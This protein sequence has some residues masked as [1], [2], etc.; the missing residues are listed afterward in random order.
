ME[1]KKQ[2][3][4]TRT[5]DLFNLRGIR[6]VTMGEVCAFQRISKKTLYKFFRDKDDLIRSCMAFEL[7]RN[8]VEVQRIVDKGLNA[9]EESFQISKFIIDQT[10]DFNLTV[11]HEL[12]TYYPDI[13]KLFEDHQNETVRVSIIDNIERG[14]K[15][16]FYRPDLNT[17]IVVGLH[18]TLM[19]NLF[20]AN[21]LNTKHYSFTEIYQELFN[22]HIYG[23]SSPKGIEYLQK[24][25][26]NEL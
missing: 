22:Y 11:F 20:T 5:L 12:Q 3:I 1:E 2:G 18:L 23:I 9:I 10:S 19:Y 24:R 21:L 25:K 7:E 17:E 6:A 26:Q 16:G 13:Y 8:D 4:L 15:E 14:I